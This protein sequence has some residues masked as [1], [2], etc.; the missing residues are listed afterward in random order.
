MFHTNEQYLKFTRIISGLSKLY[1]SVKWREGLDMSKE[2]VLIFTKSFVLISPI[3]MVMHCL[4]KDIKW[5]LG[6]LCDNDC[7]IKRNSDS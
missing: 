6:I 2:M 4:C 5:V 3:I 1:K 7:V